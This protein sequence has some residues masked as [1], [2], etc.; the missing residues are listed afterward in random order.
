[1][2]TRLGRAAEVRQLFDLPSDSRVYE[3]ARQGLLPG[4]VR[5]G[6]CVRFDV[7]KIL[8]FVEKGGRALPGGGRRRAP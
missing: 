2:P 8:A 7:A 6:R 1:M 5:L 4:V 3:L